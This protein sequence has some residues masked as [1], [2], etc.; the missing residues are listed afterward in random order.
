MRYLHL[1]ENQIL[2][3]HEVIGIINAEEKILP[4]T[5]DFIDKAE[6]DKSFHVIRSDLK[7][8]SVVIAENGVYESPISSVTL[9]KRAMERSWEEKNE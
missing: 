4:D 7:T 8:K 5:A 1:G 6:A 9:Y 3:L 2:P